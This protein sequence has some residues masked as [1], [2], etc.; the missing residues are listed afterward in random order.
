MY[1]DVRIG[2]NL[3]VALLTAVAV[4]IA[5]SLVSL[6]AE[7]LSKG[8]TYTYE[9]KGPLKRYPDPDENKL[10][11]GILPEKPDYMEPNWVGF[12][13]TEPYAVTIDL[14]SSFPIKQVRSFHM[15]GIAGI[16]WPTKIM[17]VVSQDKEEWSEPIEFIPEETPTAAAMQWLTI[18][19]IN[20]SG[21]YVQIAFFPPIE[22]KNV[23]S[24][25]IEVY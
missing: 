8:K 17:I 10:T 4:F 19:N 23:F 6:A 1:R 5:M 20:L 2:R 3:I 7:P 11:N 9:I 14:G 13:S 15:A 21:R 12:W 25:E 16:V 18:D 24:G 22:G